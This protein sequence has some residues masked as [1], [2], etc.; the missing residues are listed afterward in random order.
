MTA[1]RPTRSLLKIFT[2]FTSNS[3]LKSF[4][5]PKEMAV[6]PEL[7]WFTNSDFSGTEKSSQG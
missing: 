3:I 4:E 7:L 1:K 6:F 5:P 2:F